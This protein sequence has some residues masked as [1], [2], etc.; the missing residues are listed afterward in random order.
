MSADLPV[1]VLAD[2]ALA[3]LAI[4]PAGRYLDA[5][6][7]RGGHAG[8]IL[9]Q[10][11]PDG[12][13]FAID[14]DP[15]AIREAE[16]RYGQDPRFSI[17]Q[18]NFSELADALTALGC[19]EPLDGILFDLGVSSPQLDDAARGF[20][21]QAD[22]PLDMRMDTTTG[23][24]A[25]EWLAQVDEATLA[26]ILKR[27]GEERFARRVAGA[28][29]KARSEAPLERTRQLAELVARAIPT[30]EAGKHPATRSFQAIRMAVNDELASIERALE[31]AL[32]R[33]A[34]GGRL[35]VIAF[36]SLEDRIV[37]RFLRAHS[38]APAGNRRLPPPVDAPPP[39]LAKPPKAIRAGA[40]EL[41]R[42]PRARSAVMRYAEKRRAS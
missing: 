38:Q 23:M 16:R 41:E 7:G 17:R 5:T 36:H 24:T 31:A 30:R 33:L 35:V 2:E 27:W 34:P 32:A 15:T 19:E 39:L 29:V 10:L 12:R 25:A 3:A 8:A 13:L 6:F 1:P 26:D 37:K 28:I 4:D 14:R 20:S 22:G 21:F 42:N 11:G 18:A 9:E 40:E